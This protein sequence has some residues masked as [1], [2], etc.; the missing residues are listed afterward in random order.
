VWWRARGRDILRPHELLVLDAVRDRLD[1]KAAAILER[2]LESI[3]MVQRLHDGREVNLY[4][5][6]RGP[7]RH[8][9]AIAFPN[10]TTELRVATVDITGPSGK[11]KADVFVVLRHL[12]QIAFT[13]S[14]KRLGQTRAIE[15]GGVTIHADPMLPTADDGIEECLGAMDVRLRAELASMWADGSAARFGLASKAETYRIQLDDGDHVVLAQL[16]DTSYLVAPI[17]PPRPRVRRFWPDG[18][19]VRE[20]PDLRSAV[21]DR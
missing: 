18:D 8:D 17:D 7:Q 11:G 19:L 16:D 1:P 20:Y 12:F 3:E 21:D 4:P 9:P 14:P 15:V 6:R 5:S 13:P 2:Q 10:P